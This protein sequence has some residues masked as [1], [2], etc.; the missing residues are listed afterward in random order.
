MSSLS[1]SS[2][3]DNTVSKKRAL[4]TFAEARKIARSY[5]FTKQ[6]F[7][8][9][10][11]PGAYQLPK[12]PQDVWKEEWK[13]WD[14]FLGIC[15]DFEQGRQIARSLDG[16][17]TEED[18]LRLFQEKKFNDDDIAS[19]LPYRPDIKYKDKWISWEDFLQDK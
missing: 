8:D 2:S 4:Y 6:E 16:I 9:Y 15:L 10:D 19:R 5:G 12:N 11:C 1:S 7:L 14:D 18:Y 17:D 3:K 13:G